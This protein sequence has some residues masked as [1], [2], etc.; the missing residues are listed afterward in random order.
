MLI[1]RHEFLASQQGV[2]LL[3]VLITIVILA[4]GLLG[5]AGLQSKIQLAEVE[6]FQRSQAIVLLSDMT[7][8]ISAN[9]ANA[10]SYVSASAYGTADSQPSSCTALAAGASRD[11]CEWSNALKGASETKSSAKV[12]AMLGARGCVVEIQA[13]DATT[14]VCKPG[15]YQVTVAWQGM[16]KTV[17]PSLACGQNSYGDDEYR[18]A[19]ASRVVVPLMTCSMS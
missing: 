19:I 17:A 5:L 11:V 9:T 16:G 2:T 18:R 6:S 7:E 14:G 3:E 15:I 1:M 8:R 10:S 13:Q 12:G 4:F